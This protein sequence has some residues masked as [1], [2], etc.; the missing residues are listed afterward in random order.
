VPFEPFEESRDERAA[1]ARLHAF[2]GEAEHHAAPG[3]APH[4]AEAEMTA[5]PRRKADDEITDRRAVEES[6][7]AERNRRL[8]GA[9][10]CRAEPKVDAPAKGIARP[11]GD[12]WGREPP[13]QSAADRMERLAG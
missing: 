11:R 5:R 6:R 2:A 1:V 4:I 12:G 13:A 9:R 3:G 8:R 10:R 7:P